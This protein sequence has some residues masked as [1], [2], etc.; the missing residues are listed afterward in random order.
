[1][2]VVGELV[3]VV[4]QSVRVAAAS[5]AGGRERCC[6]V[7]VVG[8]V[9]VLVARPGGPEVVSSSSESV[10]SAS[11]SCGLWLVVGECVEVR[12]G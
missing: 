3:A 9:E 10:S 11:L 12:V 1:M 7:V 6:G 8:G 4:G 2:V 5:W